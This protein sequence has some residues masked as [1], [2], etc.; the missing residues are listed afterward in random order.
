MKQKGS[1]TVFF[2]LI[3]VLISALI[4]TCI[5]SARTAGLRF[6]AQTAAGS[7]MQSVFADYHEELW[8]RYRVFFHHDTD[9]LQNDVEEYLSYYE[10]PEK[11]VFGLRA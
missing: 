6:M 9:G 4:G 8:E 5:E 11:G 10:E 7:A 1:M 2:C 3:T